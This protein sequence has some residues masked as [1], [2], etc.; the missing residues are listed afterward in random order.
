MSSDD[1]SVLLQRVKEGRDDEATAGLWEQYFDKLVHVARRNI[2]S[3]PKRAVDEE[4][5]ALSAINSFFKAAEAGR[6]SNLQNRDELWKML[7]TMV[8]RKAN[9]QK[10]KA[11][12]QKRGGGDVRGESVF[13]RPGDEASPGLAGMPDEELVTDLMSQCQE[14]IGLLDDPLMKEIAVMMM[15][16]YTIDEIAEAKSVS[17]ST[18][19]RKKELIKQ[20]WE[21]KMPS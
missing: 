10:E 17:R 3:L 4:D 16:G 9:R 5:V 8:I 12:A 13:M 21:E 11:L 1:I 7:V 2:G 20:L 19:K 6:L 18:V 14:M 15:E